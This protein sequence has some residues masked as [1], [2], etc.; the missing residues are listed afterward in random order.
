MPQAAKAEHEGRNKQMH[1]HLPWI[2][3]RSCITLRLQQ[4]A[5]VSELIN[6]KVVEEYRTQYLW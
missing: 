6:V 2:L 5:R 3:R 4:D 1:L